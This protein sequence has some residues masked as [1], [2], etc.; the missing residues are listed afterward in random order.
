MWDRYQNFKIKTTNFDVEGNRIHFH[1]GDE[2]A[3]AWT[4]SE[5]TTA[6]ILEH[7]KSVVQTF[8]LMLFM[9]NE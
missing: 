3:G 9:K 2:A 4:D 6:L 7:Y 1:E 5:I 8:L